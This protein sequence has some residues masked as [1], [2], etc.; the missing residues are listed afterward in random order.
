[1]ILYHQQKYPDAD[2]HRARSLILA[3]Y[4]SYYCKNFDKNVGAVVDVY[5]DLPINKPEIFRFFLDIFYRQEF[6][7][8]AFTVLDLSKIVYLCFDRDTSDFEA[9]SR[10]LLEKPHSKWFEII[11]TKVST[12]PI[13]DNATFADCMKFYFKCLEVDY[14]KYAV[15]MEKIHAKL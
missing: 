7:V 2:S 9:L 10:I 5:A 6:T 4:T 12:A 13:F 3:I 14:N 11:K 1:M 15:E 8:A